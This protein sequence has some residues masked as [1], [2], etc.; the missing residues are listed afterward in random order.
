V[1]DLTVLIP[2]AVLTLA[3]AGEARAGFLASIDFSGGTPLTP[4]IESSAGYAFTVGATPVSV[5]SLGLYVDTA[6]ATVRLYEVGTTTN[7]AS[8]AVSNLSSLSGDSRY[9]YEVLGSPVLLSAGARYAVVADLAPSTAFVYLVSGVT[10]SH[11][12]HSVGGISQLFAS[13]GFPSGDATGSGPYFGPA[14]EVQSA[15]PEPAT[16]ALIATGALGLI[17][18]G[19]RKRCA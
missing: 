9:R 18:R 10:A 8:V 2:I 14:L 3:A 1:R 16:W 6:S 12:L 5:V 13:G 7:L 15:V 19:R 11:G 4:A 17:A